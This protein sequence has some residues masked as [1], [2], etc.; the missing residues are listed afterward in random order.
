[1]ATA[2]QTDWAAIEAR[3]RTSFSRQWKLNENNPFE[4]EWEYR[5]RTWYEDLIA[6]AAPVFGIALP[7][8]ER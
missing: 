5:F 7:S 4:G 1:M 6:Q 3:A 8:S 2:T